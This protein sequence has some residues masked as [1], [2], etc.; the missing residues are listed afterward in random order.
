MS[1]ETY[2]KSYQLKSGPA[3]FELKYWL[4]PGLPYFNGNVI[5]I[6]DIK[7]G[8]EDE[9]RLTFASTVLSLS[10]SDPDCW[11]FLILKKACN[12][13]PNNLSFTN[14]FG[15]DISHYVRY[16][17]NNG[18]EFRGYIDKESISWDEDT[19]T[20][21]FDVL[22]LSTDLKNIYGATNGPEA[23]YMHINH[24]WATVKT[25][26]K[27]L[28]YNV[29][30][31]L[32]T[33]EAPGFNG[34]YLNHDWEFDNFGEVSHPLFKRSW[35]MN[36]DPTGYDRIQQWVKY[37]FTNTQSLAEILKHL[38]A[39][40]AMSIGISSYNKVFVVKRFTIPA[41]TPTYSLNGKLL[42]GYQKRI[43]LKN[44]IGARV[45][46]QK[47]ST[48]YVATAGTFTTNNSQP[49][50]KAM[51]PDVIREITGYN[52]QQIAENTSGQTTYRIFK[53]NETTPHQ[54]LNGVIDPGL[55]IRH[56]C[57]WVLAAWLYHSQKEMKEAVEGEAK[58]LNYYMHRFYSHTKNNIT[59][60]YRPIEMV[61]KTVENRTQLNL[62]ET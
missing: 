7:Y 53:D 14:P 20:V 43:H 38:A 10:F 28:Q 16:T 49:D 57:H 50:G 55:G 8:Y 17:F 25:V 36:V 48:N 22:D 35:N 5:R 62:L 41:D 29:T 6:G 9:D 40:N 24:I 12:N 13:T 33:F 34:I 31:N 11:N 4:E 44:I 30:N 1:Y 46:I 27:D 18:D 58:G 56:Y 32:S 37:T 47:G 39:E 61:K 59:T 45:N 60:I 26:F 23:W 42:A 51:Y 52:T 2:T 15:Y 19:K 21:N 54:V 3:T